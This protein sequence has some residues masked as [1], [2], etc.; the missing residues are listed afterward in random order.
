VI[1]SGVEP[2]QTYSFA[3]LSTAQA[4]DFSVPVAIVGTGWE[5]RTGADYRWDNARHRRRP[6]HVVQITVAGKGLFNGQTLG[7]DDAF[8][9]S[10]DQDFEYRH[11][12]GGPWEFLW[13]IVEGPLADQSMGLVRRS[14]PILS[15]GTDSRPRLVLQSFLQRL[16][17]GG[18]WDRYALS[19]VGYE[20]CLALVK[21]LE[22]TGL[23]PGDGVAAEARSWVMAHL[24]DATVPGLA[25]RFGYNP[26]YFA[27]F[28]LR[29]TGQ[30]PQ[31]FIQGCKMRYARLL[32][33]GTARTVGAISAEL[34]FAEDN[35]FSR[36]FWQHLGQSPQE[37]RR[38][39][40]DSLV[41]DELIPL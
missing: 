18:R 10:W 1:K 29:H 17:L 25:A 9:A 13:L 27:E 31:R 11:P 15:L 33:A 34:G 2:L 28:F 41:S 40:Q 16:A 21:H 14:G 37:F 36:V 30:T 35:Y 19:T 4:V 12:G 20:F 32:L 23:S 38:T 8:V 22:S 26:K 3:E 5:R 39:H 6:Y 7:P 24:S